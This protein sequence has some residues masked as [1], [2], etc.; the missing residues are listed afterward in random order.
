MQIF[1]QFL[2]D[3]IKNCDDICVCIDI[4]QKAKNK[5]ELNHCNTFATQCINNIRMLSDNLRINAL[6]KCRIIDQLRQI[7]K[8]LDSEIDDLIDDV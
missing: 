8:D 4:F 6:E 1:N 2:D 7:S 5:E 3:I